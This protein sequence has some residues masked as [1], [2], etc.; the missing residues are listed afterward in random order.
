[1]QGNAVELELDLEL[2]ELEPAHD[3][4]GSVWAR[5][6]IRQI[7]NQ[8][9][10]K[11]TSQSRAEITALGLQHQLVTA[12]TSFI[13]VEKEL[14]Q[15]LDGQLVMETES[16][17]SSKETGVTASDSSS[18]KNQTVDSKKQAAKKSV[19]QAVAN[20]TQHDTTASTTKPAATPVAPASRSA[21]PVTPST[22]SS[23]GSAPSYSAPSSATQQPA[24]YRSAPSGGFG[25]G[26]GRSGGG[27]IGPFSALLSLAGA[28]AAAMLRRKNTS[29]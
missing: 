7:W 10:G 28:G 29:R 21:A 1:V 25:A 20:Q 18:V 11:E 16:D 23:S 8:N 17:E 6:R 12:Y 2:P 13:A 9:V 15:P 27:P 19:Q 14:E 5:Q 3:S 4:I 24:Q 26:S 22:S